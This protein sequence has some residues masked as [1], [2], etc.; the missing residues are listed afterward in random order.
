MRRLLARYLPFRRQPVLAK[1]KL[2]GDSGVGADALSVRNRVEWDAS[3]LP[4]EKIERL[5]E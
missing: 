1:A 3:A 4:G 5:H 2:S